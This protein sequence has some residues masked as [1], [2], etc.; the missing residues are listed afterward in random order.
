MNINTIT[1]ATKDTPPRGL[2]RIWP[3]ASLLVGFSPLL[4]AAPSS[5]LATSQIGH[6]ERHRLYVHNHSPPRRAR[7]SI[8]SSSPNNSFPQLRSHLSCH[9]HNLITATN[10]R[11]PWPKINTMLN[12]LQPSTNYCGRLNYLSCSLPYTCNIWPP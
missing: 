4:G 9:P 12:F 11:Q 10:P 6:N 1:L 5:R 2:R 8:G 3:V 7:N